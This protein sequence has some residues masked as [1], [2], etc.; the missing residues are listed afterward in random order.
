MSISIKLSPGVVELA[1]DGAHHGDGV[2]LGEVG[3]VGTFLGYVSKEEP[4]Y[5]FLSKSAQ[6]LWS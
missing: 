1:H 5:Q 4:E 2:D 6:G 3:H